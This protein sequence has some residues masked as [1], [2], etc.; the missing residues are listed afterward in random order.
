MNIIIL[1]TRFSI[2]LLYC[3]L[4]LRMFGGKHLYAGLIS[5]FIGL[6]VMFPAARLLYKGYKPSPAAAIKADLHTPKILAWIRKGMALFFCLTVVGAFEREQY[7]AG[8]LIFIICMILLSPLERIVF[9]QGNPFL[10]SDAPPND[11]R[12]PSIVLGRN[13]GILLYVT[14]I[15]IFTDH[16][17]NNTAIALLI[18]GMPL[19][20]IRPAILWLA[21]YKPTPALSPAMP[22]TA[23]YLPSVA[24]DLPS[25]V[26]DRPSFAEDLP[27]SSN[28]AI[29]VTAALK[30][31]EAVP[32]KQND[33]TPDRND[34]TLEALKAEYNGLFQLA[35][36]RRGY[37]FQDFL[38]KLFTAHHIS[39]RGAFRLTGEEIDGS[40]DLGPQTYLLEAKWQAKPCG[41][42]DLAIF[43]SK[44][45]GKSTWA[46]GIL[47]SHAGFTSDGLKAFARGKRTSIIGMDGQDILLILEGAIAL[48]EAIKRKARKAVENNDFFVPLAELLG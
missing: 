45:E 10:S 13:A 14:G 31:S 7:A 6:E 24:G 23:G 16:T 18:T 44:V 25:I 3:M 32:G 48:G 4:S 30:D 19:L 35:P 17:N 41:Q 42:S 22:A 39:A 26:E 28:A 29:H 12:V 38:N 47:I 36:Q 15:F 40:F 43:N 20:F 21:P 11:W 9:G 27:P 8:V 33:H 37:A 5:V 1:I 46:R 2:G 34:H